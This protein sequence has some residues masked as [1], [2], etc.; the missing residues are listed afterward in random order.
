MFN[1]HAIFVSQHARRFAR[2]VICNIT[3]RKFPRDKEYCSLLSQKE[4]E[5]ERSLASK[6]LDW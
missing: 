3:Q 1:E 2:I 6:C 4:V 5:V